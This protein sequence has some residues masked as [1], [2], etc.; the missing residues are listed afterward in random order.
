V[1][2]SVFVSYVEL[3]AN[4]DALGYVHLEAIHHA[5]LAVALEGMPPVSALVRSQE[6]FVIG[7]LERGDGG[8]VGRPLLAG[9]RDGCH[10]CNEE[11]KECQRSMPFNVICD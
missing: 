2:D 1:T 11:T 5:I 10:G 7:D 4:L 8:R 3:D 9:E 6:E